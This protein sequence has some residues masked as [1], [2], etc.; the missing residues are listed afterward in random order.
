MIL[1]QNSKKVDF[2]FAYLI[3]LITLFIIYFFNMNITDIETAFSNVPN[4]VKAKLDVKLHT[5]PN[6]P[7]CMIKQ[8]IYDYFRSLPKFNCLVTHDDLSNIVQITSN[9][10]DLLIPPDHPSRAKSDTYYVNE[11]QVLRSQT[12]AHQCELLVA[13]E[14]S[15]LV[16]GDV[17]RKDEI[18]RCHYNVFHQMEGVYILPNTTHDDVELAK[19]ELQSTLSGLVEY[20][21]PDCEYRFNGDY[22]PFTDPSFE[23]EVKFNGKWLEI[24]GCGVIHRTILTNLG[25]NEIGFAFGLGLERL[26]MIL[27]NIPDIR[28]FWTDDIKFTSQFNQSTNFRQ[29]TFKPYSKLD[30]TSRDISFFIPDSQ[31]NVEHVESGT[32]KWININDFFDLV[33]ETCGDNIEH[34]ALSDAFHN[35]K[36]SK[37][38][39]TFRLTFSPNSDITNSATFS[40]LANQ[41]MDQLGSQILDKLDVEPRFTVKK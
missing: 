37:Y 17:Y 34:V 11:T 13:G 32:F 14:R 23:I 31:I 6:H 12:S 3:L 36:L 18:D 28:L 7:L 26:A 5:Q 9:F 15:F 2:L 33:R 10:D 30:S 40:A 19:N 1:L 35:K 25:V 4:T 16:S 20:L 24:L 8:A 41:Y 22:F 27:F 29:I 21:F 39:H 38:S